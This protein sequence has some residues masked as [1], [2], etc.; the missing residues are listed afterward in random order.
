MKQAT[1]FAGKLLAVCLALVLA[2]SMLAVPAAWADNGNSTGTGSASTTPP[3]SSDD[4]GSSGIT[5]GTPYIT[6]Y[7]VTPQLGVA[8]ELQRI[9][10]GQ[11]CCII[12]S[13]CDPRFTKIPG[14][15]A[16]NNALQKM[17]EQAFPNVKITSTYNFASPSLGD[18]QIGGFA[19][20][21]NNSSGAPWEAGPL[22]YHVSFNDIT[23]LGGSNKLSFDVSYSGQQGLELVNLSQNISQC[24]GATNVEGGKAS[25]IVVRSAGYGGGSVV[26]GQQFTL[27]ADVFVTAGT[28][29]AE[30]VAVSLTLPEQVTVVSGSSQIFVGNMAAG[31]STSV[32]FLLN[33]SATAAAGS[34]NITINVNGN[35]ASDGAA[36]TTTMPIT[37][38]IVQPERFEVSRTDF[39]EVINMGE[40][41]YGSVSFVNKGKGTIY[42]VSA[43]LRGEGFTTT[44]GNQFVGNVASG[45]ESSADFTISPTQAGSINAQL[46]ITYE[47]EQ[48]EEKTIT[49]DIT[50]T[51]EEMSF[52]DPG[53]MPGM[54]DMPT[55][56]TQ[57]GMPLWAWA[58]IVVLA[59]GVVATVVVIVRK[60]IKKRKENEKL[61]E[62][63]DEDI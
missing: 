18:I 37:V 31:E 39:P 47:N 7:T 3:A 32:N 9:Q 29:G 34:A 51:V 46:V 45:T 52:E 62:E 24:V 25:A 41:T 4:G 6:G 23:Y 28:T 8:G 53:M 58:V 59:A 54:G 21:K 22:E 5:S 33:A 1:N 19:Y 35:A 40:E 63:D 13:I 17:M 20:G 36:L 56:P 48:A 55:E 60:K 15:E 12:V 2:A 16:H 30:N 14:D 10:P 57:T 61:M 42:N 38:P 11:K 27:T 50:F 26:A 43:E 49:K 44:E